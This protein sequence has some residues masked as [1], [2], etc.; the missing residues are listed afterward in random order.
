[1]A[2][3]LP[4][5]L[6]A[7]A[8]VY[9][10]DAAG[11]AGQNIANSSQAMTREQL[12]EMQR[13]FNITNP[14][15]VAE[16][17]ATQET[18]NKQF[19]AGL[20]STEAQFNANQKAQRVALQQSTELSN[21]GLAN[22]GNQFNSNLS[23]TEN[24][25]KV[26]LERD[27][28]EMANQG[29]QFNASLGS[30]Q[31]QFNAGLGGQDILKTAYQR[32]MKN[33]AGTTSDAEKKFMDTMG[34]ASP[35]VL[36]LQKDIGEKG[37]KAMQDAAG[38]SAANLQAQGV[39]GG[40]AAT[41]QNRAV[42]EVGLQAQR[43]I[44]E[45]SASDAQARQAQIAGYQASKANLGNQFATSET[46]A[47]M[48]DAQGNPVYASL[49]DKTAGA[50]TKQVNPQTFEQAQKAAIAKAGDK[51]TAPTAISTAYD[52]TIRPVNVSNSLSGL[53]IGQT[54]NP[55]GEKIATNVATGI[56]LPG[57]LAGSLNTAINT[58][59][60]IEELKAKKIA[61]QQAL[62]NAAMRQMKL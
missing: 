61:E 47:G 5:V 31:A 54:T 60:S 14:Q 35:E 21:A 62:A 20:G 11:K 45:L 7:G 10:A 30:N 57:I 52:Q 40:Q 48:T 46:T 34:S 58:Q 3:A 18:G 29:S 13:Q 37:T 15:S 43:D 39:R 22:Q 51:T 56:P 1:M 50:T 19:G 8:T 44:N 16:F 53:Q 26:A 49:A 9:G 28:A 12:A 32:G 25:R 17:N 55:S 36:K 23:S 4:A 6:T 2:T 59:P 33:I 42:G 24:A 41:L 38:Q 27:N